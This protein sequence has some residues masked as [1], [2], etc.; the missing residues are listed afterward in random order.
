MKFLGRFGRYLLAGFGLVV[1]AI[2][3]FVQSMLFQSHV[4]ELA[5]AEAEAWV[6][7]NFQEKF[8]WSALPPGSVQ[9]GWHMGFQDH[10]WLFRL[11]LAPEAFAGLR[12]AVL[13]KNQPGTQIDDRD[14]LRSSPASFA[15]LPPHGPGNLP[16]WWEAASMRNFDCIEWR[17]HGR[18]FWFGYD[19]ERQALFIIVM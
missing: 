17:S 7:Q 11:K 9:H 15:S 2:G 14:D 18:T 10:V 13:A 4:E 16:S 8:D 12:H 3:F 6:T 1:I 19:V 5:S